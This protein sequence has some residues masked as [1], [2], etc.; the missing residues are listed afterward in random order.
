MGHPTA[1]KIARL[2]SQKTQNSYSLSCCTWNFIVDVG[3]VFQ[4]SMRASSVEIV[5]FGRSPVTCAPTLSLME[6][7]IDSMIT[8]HT[9]Y[10]DVVITR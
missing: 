5:K 7:D 2:Q 9:P 1:D 4:L 6:T 8:P 10:S 3:F